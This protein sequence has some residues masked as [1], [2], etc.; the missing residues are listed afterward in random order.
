[1][2]VLPGRMC[3][4]HNR[5]NLRTAWGPSSLA[6][7]VRQPRLGLDEAHRQATLSPPFPFT[8]SL[9]VSPLLLTPLFLL[10]SQSKAWPID[11]GVQA[12]SRSLHLAFSSHVLFHALPFNFFH[13]LTRDQ[14]SNFFFVSLSS[15]VPLICSCIPVLSP[16]YTFFLLHVLISFYWFTLLFIQVSYRYDFQFELFLIFLPFVLHS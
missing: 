4:W 9:T 13:C 2:L 6:P 1:M 14:E 8:Q 7:H 10:S 3:C 11:W 15:G 16:P 5:G 12:R